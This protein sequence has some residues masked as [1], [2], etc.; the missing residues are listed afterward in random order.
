MFQKE[1]SNFI[2]QIKD[3][4]LYL[5]IVDKFTF[6]FATET[7]KTYDA[8]VI[9]KEILAEKH[10]GGIGIDTILQHLEF[11]KNGNRITSICTILQAA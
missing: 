2:E 4:T 5:L 7:G 3:V 10:S 8:V 1:W 9:V 11:F 6:V